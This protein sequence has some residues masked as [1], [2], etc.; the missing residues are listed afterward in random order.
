MSFF[1]QFLAGAFLCNFI[2]HL[3]S[4]VQGQHFPTPFSQLRGLKVSSPVVNVLWGSFNL[5]AGIA[6]LHFYPV[7]LELGASLYSFIVGFVF[8]GVFSG[9]HFN[10][11]MG[12]NHG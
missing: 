1:L 7:A 12:N 4:G 10:R 8:L 6:L 3:V 2:P 9:W 11:V 5:G